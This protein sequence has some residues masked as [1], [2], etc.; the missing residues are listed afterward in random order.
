MC[1][2]TRAGFV[3]AIFLTLAV[4]LRMKYH[5]LFLHHPPAV[6]KNKWGDEY[7]ANIS[8]GSNLPCWWGLGRLTPR[9]VQHQCKRTCGL[10]GDV[11]VMHEVE[12][13]AVCERPTTSL[14]VV[15]AGYRRRDHSSDYIWNLRTPNTHVLFYQRE[16]IHP[17]QTGAYSG[18]CNMTGST[19]AMER[20]YGRDAAAF[21]DYAF[22]FYDSL[23]ES[24]AFLHG[25]VGHAWHT[26]CSAI[27]ERIVYY[28]RSLPNEMVTLTNMRQDWL[29]GKANAEG[30]QKNSIRHDPCAF[31]GWTHVTRRKL[32]IDINNQEVTR[33][34]NSV[35]GKWGLTGILEGPGP[36]SSCCASFIMP[37]E[38]IRTYPR[39]FYEDMRKFAMNASLDDRV[40]GRRGF[41][42]I[43][44]R[45][46]SKTQS[47]NRAWYNNASAIGK[48][49]PGIAARTHACEVSPKSTWD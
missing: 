34:M 49:E 25:H 13:N 37:A 46:F 33:A 26:T 38:R 19:L 44:Y 2:G 45:M 4:A 40:T 31:G 7:C 17:G 15:V 11:E 3:L 20:N 12:K 24:A 22:R 6:C 1:T 9:K 10:C 29:E 14:H 41:E 47:C 21:Y 43:I 36:V 48:N 8:R 35:L 32:R 28:Q 16:D 27:F 42:F 30:W 39:G 23:P 5:H 18:P